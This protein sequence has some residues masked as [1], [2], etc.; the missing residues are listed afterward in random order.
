MARSK[1]SKSAPRKKN[2]SHSLTKRDQGGRA[3]AQLVPFNQEPMTDKMLLPKVVASRYIVRKSFFNGAWLQQS[4]ATNTFQTAN[5]TTAQ[6][7]DF[8]S[9]SSVFDQYRL[10]CVEAILRPQAQASAPT[11]PS[12][13]ELLSVIDYDDSSNLTTIAQATEY[14]NCVITSPWQVSRRCFK[15][16]VAVAAYGGAFTSFANM[17][18]PWIDAASTAVQHYGI[19]YALTTGITGSLA[20]FDQIINSVWEFRATR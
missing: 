20:V 16:R 8:S 17:E 15:P 19:K 9:L 1:G 11:A 18:A 7:P 10:V 13:G 14:D 6:C 12:G 3:Q 2:K 4:A 5:F